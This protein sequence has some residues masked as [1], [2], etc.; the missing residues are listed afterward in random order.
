MPALRGAPVYGIGKGRQKNGD[1]NFPIFLA[2]L[3]LPI[4]RIIGTCPCL[5]PSRRPAP[6]AACRRQKAWVYI[7]SLC[8]LPL[9]YSP[10]RLAHTPPLTF[11]RLCHFHSVNLGKMPKA[12]ALSPSFMRGREVVF[13]ELVYSRE[14]IPVF[15]P[16]SSADPP[17]LGGRR[18]RSPL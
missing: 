4:M 10:L 14:L 13:H 1:P 7:T 2:K 11:P 9:F 6:F 16:P 15:Q 5:T 3:R 18:C 12:G 17:L 8:K